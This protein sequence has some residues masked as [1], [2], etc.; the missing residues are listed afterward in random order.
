[1]NRPLVMKIIIIVAVVVA[2]LIGINMYNGK[3]VTPPTA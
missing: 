2:V 1:M 3:P